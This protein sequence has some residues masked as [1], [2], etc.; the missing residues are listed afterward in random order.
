MQRQYRALQSIC[1][2]GIAQ[3]S[4]YQARIARTPPPYIAHMQR[5]YPNGLRHIGAGLA[6]A[7]AKSTS[8]GMNRATPAPAP[9]SAP[10]IRTRTARACLRHHLTTVFRDRRQTV[11]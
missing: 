8:A 4:Q 10:R 9:R 6:P 7:C 3:P 5:R 2:R 11:P 1:T